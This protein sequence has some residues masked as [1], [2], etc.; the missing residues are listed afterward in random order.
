MKK[1]F[2]TFI[3]FGMITL[4]THANDIIIV[5]DCS[6]R[7]GDTQE[8][9]IDLSTEVNNYRGFQA[10]ILLPQGFTVTRIDDVGR[11]V[12]ESEVNKKVGSITEVTINES[13]MNKQVVVFAIGSNFRTGDGALI[14][15]SIKADDNVV[16]GEY[17]GY[18]QNVYL[19]YASGTTVSIPDLQFNIQV[20]NGRLQITLDENSSDAPQTINESVDVYVKRTLNANEWSTICLPFSMNEEQV[21]T[22]FGDDVMLADFIEWSSDE[23]DEGNIVRILIKFATINDIEANHPCLIHVSQPLDGFSAEN[24]EINVDEEPMVQVGKKKVERGF[25]TGTYVANTTVPENNLFIYGN[26]FYYSVGLTKTK[27]FRAYFEFYDVLTSVEE[28]DTKIRYVIDDETT[29]LNTIRINDNNYGVYSIMGQYLG[30]EID[31]Q[32]LPK[33]IYLINGKAV[34]K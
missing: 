33:G 28:S 10:D 32:Y 7:P 23:D 3:M 20:Y 5:E 11:G 2:L 4:L 29:S 16:E 14:S 19:S 8:T 27:A 18:L 6:L 30:E 31:I 21:K 9:T 24:V 15:L 25:L 26:K 13:I 34:L 1:R 22:A 12:E 17:V